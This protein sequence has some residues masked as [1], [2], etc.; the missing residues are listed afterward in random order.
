MAS[1]WKLALTT[2]MLIYDSVG[3]E[4]TPSNLLQMLEA[5]ADVQQLH[6]SRK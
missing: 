4:S 6:L 2:K 1:T 3:S 5:V